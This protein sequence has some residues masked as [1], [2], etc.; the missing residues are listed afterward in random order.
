MTTAVSS[1]TTAAKLFTIGFTKKSAEQF[2]TSL[3]NAGIR[4]LI[5]IRR[6]P[7]SQL[8]GFAKGENLQ[9][10]LR[11]TGGI[12]YE[13]E[14]AFAPTNELFRAYKHNGLAWE[15]YER[16][17]NEL[18]IERD[19]AGLQSLEHFDHACLLC[20]EREPDH[21]HRRLVAKYLQIR[22]PELEIEHL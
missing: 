12:E 7:D 10:F 17:F 5:D 20:S 22:W 14:L 21:C 1:A 2:F 9:Y 8:A 15:D 6:K 13:H 11:V 3:L 19:P 16:R 4:R 18:L